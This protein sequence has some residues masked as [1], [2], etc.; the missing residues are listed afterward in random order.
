M[1]VNNGLLD[2]RDNNPLRQRDNKKPTSEAKLSEEVLKKQI[3]TILNSDM[4]ENR[5]LVFGKSASKDDQNS[6]DSAS[7][8]NLANHI[9]IRNQI[10]ANQ[11]M[12]GRPRAVGGS[13]VSIEFGKRW[14]EQ[15][16]DFQLLGEIENLQQLSFVEQTIT[17]EMVKEF[18]RISTLTKLIFE[19]CEFEFTQKPEW[20][21]L[22]ELELKDQDVTTKLVEAWSTIPSLRTLKF[23]ACSIKDDA[24]NALS[25]SKSLMSLQ[26]DETEIEAAVFD[27]LAIL[28]QVNYVNLTA[29]K[30][31]T[32]DYK[33]LLA[34]RPNLQVTFTAQAFFGVRGPINVGVRERFRLDEN[35]R[36]V[37]VIT[38]DQTGCSITDV[39]AGSGAHKAGIKIGDVI[40]K[41]NGQEIEKFED[42]R[43]HI[44]QFRAGEKLDVTVRR[45]DKPLELQVELGSQKS[46]PRFQP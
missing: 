8:Q 31:Q 11:I 24:L 17:S 7:A 2:I 5:E 44:A 26:F 27:S 30:F 32:K 35:G 14:K 1:V 12:M 9:A 3:E 45:G 36:P 23:S 4:E 34:F 40:E 19:N 38:D 16:H 28:N 10:R 20:N 21:S 37:A 46:A 33:A 43:L 15:N 6:V 42:L 18:S 39:I 13:G 22:V 25:E 29:C 41:V